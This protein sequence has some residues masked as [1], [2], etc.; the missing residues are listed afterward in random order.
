MQSGSVPDLDEKAPYIPVAESLPPEAL[1]PS[2]GPVEMGNRT[3]ERIPS[4]RFSSILQTPSS[5]GILVSLATFIMKPFIDVH[6][7]NF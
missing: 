5:S 2:K 3:G 1:D 6:T 7:P 4:M